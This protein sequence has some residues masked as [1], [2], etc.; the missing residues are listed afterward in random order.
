MV[1]TKDDRMNA[2]RDKSAL[3]MGGSRNPRKELLQSNQTSSNEPSET[4][5][6][7]AARLTREK[8]EA[9]NREKEL[10]DLIARN[11]EEN[12]KAEEQLR[13]KKELQKKL[14]TYQN[15]FNT[16]AKSVTVE[17]EG[18]TP[19]KTPTGPTGLSHPTK[20]L[21]LY[22]YQAK[23]NFAKFELSK[24]LSIAPFINKM[25]D[26]SI[27]T[28]YSKDIDDMFNI[29]FWEHFNQSPT[30]DIL[31][32][33][34]IKLMLFADVFFDTY[35]ISRM[36]G[37]AIGSEYEFD[38]Y[39]PDDRLQVALIH[40]FKQIAANSK[41][42]EPS[43]SMKTTGDFAQLFEN[44]ISA[45]VRNGTGYYQWGLETGTY[46]EFDSKHFKNVTIN[47]Q[48]GVTNTVWCL[49]IASFV[50]EWFDSVN[51]SATIQNASKIVKDADSFYSWANI[52]QNTHNVEEHIMADVLIGKCYD[53]FSA[54]SVNNNNSVAYS[55]FDTTTVQEK[56]DFVESQ[57]GS[58]VNTTASSQY[59]RFL[60]FLNRVHIQ[61][62]LFG[63][64][65]TL[66]DED[67]LKKRI[68]ST[69]AKEHLLLVA[70]IMLL[71]EETLLVFDKVF[72]QFNHIKNL[73]KLF[74]IYK[75]VV[76][77]LLQTGKRKIHDLN[78][79]SSST[80]QILQKIIQKIGETTWGFWFD[81]DVQTGAFN[82]NAVDSITR[83]KDI[84]TKIEFVPLFNI[85]HVLNTAVEDFRFTDDTS[86][87]SKRLIKGTINGYGQPSLEH[88]RKI[89][90][91]KPG[92]KFK[93]T[94]Q[95][96]MT[97]RVIGGVNLIVYKLVWIEFALRGAVKDMED[98]MLKYFQNIS[99]VRENVLT[100]MV[101][102]HT[103]SPKFDRYGSAPDRQPDYSDMFDGKHK[104]AD[105]TFETI[106]DEIKDLVSKIKKMNTISPKAQL[107][108]MD[109]SQV[110]S[111][112]AIEYRT[113]M[114]VLYQQSSESTNS[115][116]Y[117]DLKSKLDSTTV[118]NSKKFATFAEIRGQKP[119]IRSVDVLYP[120]GIGPNS[121]SPD[122]N[123]EYTKF[124][125]MFTV[126]QYTV[127]HI[128]KRY[129]EIVQHWDAI[130]RDVREIVGI[131]S[132]FAKLND[133][134]KAVNDSIIRIRP[135]LSYL[136]VVTYG[137]AKEQLNIDQ[138]NESL[139]AFTPFLTYIYIDIDQMNT[140]REQ[141][142]MHSTYFST[143]NHQRFKD[144]GLI[145]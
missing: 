117:E 121:G 60:S 131:P 144:V 103:K 26:K 95:D 122:I 126:I 77:T 104:L 133:Y 142:T 18:K 39:N 89:D 109:A 31:F 72:D 54:S 128:K 130:K 80:Y 87:L 91:L 116:T 99:I 120:V 23:R 82:V 53:L 46:N 67:T 79:F 139:K 3:L 83:T 41:D 16:T 47:D 105:K 71:P 93:M 48:T 9:D 68:N 49:N 4:N 5:E 21:F 27:Q 143:V 11:N 37:L 123:L 7:L 45:D 66:L 6:Q 36:V 84:R 17:K 90:H 115:P 125:M 65:S 10:E 135:Y 24:Y 40:I 145:E 62:V 92:A 108:K 50:N 101:T 57:I 55:S 98:Y 97:K 22:S 42:I 44:L 85:Q 64:D 140:E 112:T 102:I 110:K 114:R 127:L 51:E 19:D 25:G 30:N 75:F 111:K 56:Y 96:K 52:K 134:V 20:K 70:L 12:R 100:N 107:Y 76:C 13:N 141:Q 43:S 58:S 88:L 35:V 2:P 113:I 132:T 34:K 14:D 63:R 136:E 33:N 69:R 74:L 38:K 61:T 118:D 73:S 29:L 32:T 28:A 15:N 137:E 119:V 8:R 59:L 86:M 81:K 78:N 129:A 94:G 124:A 138:S 106:A 1:V